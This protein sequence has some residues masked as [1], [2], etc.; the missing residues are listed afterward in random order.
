LK[1]LDV[2][3]DEEGPKESK[4]SPKAQI[5]NEKKSNEV[6]DLEFKCNGFLL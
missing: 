1:P 3:E 4:P 2:T 6:T 5:E